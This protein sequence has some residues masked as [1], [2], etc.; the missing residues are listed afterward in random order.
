[1]FGELNPFF[2]IMYLCVSRLMFPHVC[3][4]ICHSALVLHW[5]LP[6]TQHGI[7]L[8][9]FV[10]RYNQLNDSVLLLRTLFNLSFFYVKYLFHQ[11]K[12]VLWS[13]IICRITL[14]TIQIT[15]LLLYH[16]WWKFVCTDLIMICKCY[17][18]GHSTLTLWLQM[19]TSHHTVQCWG[20]WRPGSLH[21]GCQLWHI[22]LQPSADT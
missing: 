18:F 2:E 16:T 17:M 20:W 13:R 15:I 19:T 14:N 11:K 1:M 5:G 3:L 22:L 12:Y 7:Q 10:H 4:L 6:Q 8:S 9:V 21:P